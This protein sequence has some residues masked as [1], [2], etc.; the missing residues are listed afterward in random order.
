[1]GTR[2]FYGFIYKKKYYMV[3]NPYDSYFHGL[4]KKLLKEIKNMISNNHF[5]EWLSLFLTLKVID[6][7]NEEI[8]NINP[9]RYDPSFLNLLNSGYIFIE[10]IDESSKKFNFNM[11]D[12]EYFY[13]LDFDKKRFI[14]HALGFRTHKYN[15]FNGEINKVYFDDSN[16]EEDSS[17]DE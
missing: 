7:Q 10:E 16:N 12:G 11:Y 8:N 9:I 1:M 14:V 15:L 6:N 2:G 13:I 17:D 4:G 5:E 3:F